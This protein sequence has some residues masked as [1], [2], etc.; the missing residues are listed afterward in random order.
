MQI[1]SGLFD[2]NVHMYNNSASLTLSILHP[3]AQLDGKEDP[4]V[5]F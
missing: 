1:M 3:C 2:L 4:Q 5:Q